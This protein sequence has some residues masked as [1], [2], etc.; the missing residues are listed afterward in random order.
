LFV[1]G[2]IIVRDPLT[3]VSRGGGLRGRVEIPFTCLTLPHF[4]AC[5][6]SGL[7][8]PKQERKEV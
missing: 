7:V 8:F 6:K 2:C 5:P 3:F 1:Y 4:F